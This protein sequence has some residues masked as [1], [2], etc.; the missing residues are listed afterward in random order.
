MLQNQAS[1]FCNN[2]SSY[3]Y[4]TASPLQ[5][6]SLNQPA[7]Y[8]QNCLESQQYLNYNTSYL[9]TP[10]SQNRSYSSGYASENTSFNSP[11]LKNNFPYYNNNL[12]LPSQPTNGDVSA[13][14]SMTRTK[15][16][17][18]ARDE[19]GNQQVSNGNKHEI[20]IKQIFETPEP[21]AK[22]QKRTYKKIRTICNSIKHSASE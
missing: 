4:P 15:N 11:N 22:K 20:L 18:R 16:T 12:M 2:N 1:N 3:F 6:V 17:K 8:Y 13:Q 7:Y 21:T 14:I 9:S 19:N 10:N 5:A